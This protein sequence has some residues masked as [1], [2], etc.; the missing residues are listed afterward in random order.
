MQLK[1]KKI[2]FLVM[3]SYIGPLVLTFFIALF[4]L[5]M[6]F[7]WKYVDDLVGKGLEWYIIA[8][9]LFYASATFVPLALPLA[10]LLASLMT[11]GNLGEH[12][13]LVAM[14]SS[15]LSL[16]KIMM[17][18]MG[19]SI[20]ISIGAF[21][22]S[23]N[24]LPRANLKFHSIL[25]D[26]RKQRLSLNIKEG[27]FYKGIDG[28]VIRV[29]HKDEDGIT[30]RD[31]MIYDHRGGV[32]NTN[33]TLAEYGTMEI[34]P[35]QKSLSFTLYNGNNYSEDTEGRKKYK[36][37]PFRRTSFSKQTRR[38]GLAG[39][40]LNRTDESLF[41][42]NYHM[43]N[44]RQLA[45]SR[46]SLEV[47]LKE[48]NAEVTRTLIAGFNHFALTDT[49]ATDYAV[50]LEGKPIDTLLAAYDVEMKGRILESALSAARNTKERIRAIAMDQE[51][52]ERKI[53]KHEVEFHRKFTLSFAC[54]I[55]FFIGAPLGAIIRK[56]GLGMPV[57]VSVLMFVVYHI[58]SMMGEKFA[59]ELVIPAWQGMWLASA[60]FLPLGA[61]LTLKATTDAPL[62]D[63]DHW[64]KIIRSRFVKKEKS[65]P[66][67]G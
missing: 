46:D 23:N 47:E 32:G 65:K 21:Y 28:F 30:L 48:R 66:L 45:Q 24:I 35:D 5:L 14:K 27:V 2:H 54:L 13:E 17:P 50:P 29:A 36:S 15:G 43:F 34:S 61:F 4:I 6:Q 59:K 58:S 63:A 56:G 10:I 49:L 57:V 26:V 19:L 41:R 53:R 44:I 12:Y 62:L 51:Y 25:Y 40:E 18:L 67:S 16:R 9:L 38:F 31:I 3:K 39:F 33:V 52:R 64:R 8:E 1:L 37:R 22:F 20:L 42:N 55:L 60:I 11:F 7:L